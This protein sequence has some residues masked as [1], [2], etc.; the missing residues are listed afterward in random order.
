MAL[1][2]KPYF[3]VGMRLRRGYRRVGG[4]GATGG[5][6]TLGTGAGRGGINILGVGKEGAAGDC[7]TLG[8]GVAGR[9]YKPG[10]R[11][12]GG[13]KGR[14]RENGA[15]GGGGKGGIG[16]IGGG[17][18]I[19]PVLA[20]RT[21]AGAISLVG[22]RAGGGGWRD[23]VEATGVVVVARFKIVAISKKAFAVVEPNFREG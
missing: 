21:R 18:D 13:S 1:V 15:E 8:A 10:D 19:G 20:P 2:A 23:G 16:G 6:A 11:E 12:E 4:I 9:G 14:R 5:A 17:E 7:N 3:E 22:G